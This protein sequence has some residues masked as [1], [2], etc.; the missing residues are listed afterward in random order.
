MQLD[1]N[2]E[3]AE[4]RPALRRFVSDR[5]EPLVVQLTAHGL[6]GICVGVTAAPDVGTKTAETLIGEADEALV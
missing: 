3:L 6:H 4:M 2:P 5:L 1:I